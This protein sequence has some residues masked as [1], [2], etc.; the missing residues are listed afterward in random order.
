MIAR[1]FA[2]ATLDEPIALF[3]IGASILTV[4]VV[5]I[6]MLLRGQPEQPD[7]RPKPERVDV[8]TCDVMRPR[9]CQREA[10]RVVHGWKLC[11]THAD[12]LAARRGAS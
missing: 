12:D 1:S 3:L 6:M 4:V 8:P 11:T 10:T 7:E 2:D 9:I 5:I